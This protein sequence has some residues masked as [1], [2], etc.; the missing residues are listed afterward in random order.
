MICLYIG[1]AR[2]FVDVLVYQVI[3]IEMWFSCEFLAKFDRRKFGSK[4]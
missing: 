4:A 2:F 1:I 3:E